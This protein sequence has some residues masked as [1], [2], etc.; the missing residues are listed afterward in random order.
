MVN[1]YEILQRAASLKEETVLNSI[2]PERAGGIMYDTLLALNDLWLQQGSALV[3][4]KIY[5]SVAAMEADTAPVSD[6]TGKPLRPG[7]IVVIA[8]SDSDNGSVYRY[9]GTDAPS[10]SLVGAI[11]NLTPVD[12]LDSDSTTL[13]LAAH[14]GKVLDG[15]IGQLGQITTENI[16]LNNYSLKGF[17][18]SGSNTWYQ[19]GNHTY[20]PMTIQEIKSIIV[21]ANSN[22]PAYIAFLKGYSQA[23][24]GESPNFCVGYAQRYVINIGEE[25]SFDLPNDIQ[26]L[27]VGLV[28][29]DGVTDCKP[30][31]V[32]IPISLQDAYTE[33]E[34]KI[35]DG[36]LKIKVAQ[37][38][39]GNWALGR[40]GHT[41]IP[42]SEFS[43]KKTLYRGLINKVAADVFAVSEYD[44]N[45]TMSAIHNSRD[46]VFGQYEYFQYYANRPT[47]G[48]ICNAIAINGLKVKSHGSVVF[49]GS[50]REYEYSV[51]GY[52]GKDI[53]LISAHLDWS[54]LNPEPST[55]PVVDNNALRAAE[56]QQLITFAS[57]YD[58]VIIC[59]DFN[60]YSVDEYNA[61]SS[62]GYIMANHGFVGDLQTAFELY[63][64]VSTKCL[65]NIIVRGFDITNIELFG[66]TNSTQ[67]TLIYSDHI[68]ISC[69]CI[70]KQS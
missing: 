23:V 70:L 18:I 50:N 35:E 8:S 1:I 42:E 34:G 6:L 51:I 26:Y 12:S 22:S 20:I 66:D 24:Y 27:Y 13:P 53:L 61:F 28:S 16:N 10:W 49:T 46:V 32:K 56:I 58:Y 25:Q 17:C 39:V 45:F 4:S 43:E 59:G 19:P 55:Y 63:D 68:G 41:T 40:N 36:H 54:R 3:I 44:P 64:S 38:N 37:W 65:D 14:Q 15:K 62:A 67:E 69:D 30:E 2:S 21:K 11:G 33:L 60:V 31:Y 29:G 5:A 57:T 48:Y 9:N 47:D 7:Q 52:Y